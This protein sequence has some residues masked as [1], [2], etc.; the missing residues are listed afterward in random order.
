MSYSYNKL[1][2]LCLSV[3][4]LIWFMTSLYGVS[5]YRLHIDD[6]IVPLNYTDAVHNARLL[7]CTLATAKYAVILSDKFCAWIV[8]FFGVPLSTTYGPL[9][10]IITGIFLDFISN[11]TIFEMKFKILYFTVG[12]FHILFVLV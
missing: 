5:A 7:E 3:H 11:I 4:F 2:I 6:T 10:Y 9:Q 12:F 8:Y 1:I